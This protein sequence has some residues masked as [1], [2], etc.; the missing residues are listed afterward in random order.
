MGCNELKKDENRSKDGVLGTAA[1]K[2]LGKGGKPT[3]DD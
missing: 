3:E 2:S 1:S